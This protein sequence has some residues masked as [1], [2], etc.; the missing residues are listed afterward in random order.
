MP[1]QK[2]QSVVEDDW[3]SDRLG[4]ALASIIGGPILAALASASS[5][6]GVQAL[7]LV[8][9]GIFAPMFW[10]SLVIYWATGWNVSRWWDGGK[11]TGW[12][13]GV[14][15]FGVSATIIRQL[16][17]I[18]SHWFADYIWNVER[19]PWH[20]AFMVYLPSLLFLELL[21]VLGTI[22]I[23]APVTIIRRLRNKGRTSPP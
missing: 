22:I 10:G 4:Y 17:L 11:V 20:M 15:G 21:M 6:K 13:L 1:E 12:I 19:Q 23:A 16:N 9:L 7:I 14:A 5:A 2:L 8:I 3:K 18:S